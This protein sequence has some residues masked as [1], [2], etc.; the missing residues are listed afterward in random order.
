MEAAAAVEAAATRATVSSQVAWA[1]MQGAVRVVTA[2]A[3][4]SVGGEFRGLGVPWSCCGAVLISVA[5][6]VVARQ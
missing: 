4:S 6:A 2:A 3:G 5:L 1:A